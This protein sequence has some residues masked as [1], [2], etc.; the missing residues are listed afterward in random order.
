MTIKMLAMLALLIG[1]APAAETLPRQRTAVA[2]GAEPCPRT[3]AQEIVVCA[4]RPESERFRI[5]VA[6]RAPVAADLMT[7]TDR[8]HEMMDIGRVGTDSCS[9]VGPGGF[10]G[11]FLQS[12]RH[13]S[14]EKRAVRR[15]RQEEPR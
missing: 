7:A 15:A 9:P 10:T 6:L 13:G 11:C 5:P 4:R 2:S 1:A 8:V 3:T 14:S 12:V